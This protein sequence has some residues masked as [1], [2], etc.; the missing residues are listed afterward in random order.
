M[1]TRSKPYSLRIAQTSRIVKRAK[2]AF[3][4]PLSLALAIAASTA[5]A[6]APVF[7]WEQLQKQGRVSAGTVLPPESGSSGHPLRI[8]NSGPKS[9]SATVLTIDQPQL[10]GPRYMLRGQVRYDDVEGIGYL[11]MWSLF[12][13]GGQYFSRTLAEQGPMMK[14]SGTSGWRAFVLP[15]DAT[16]APRPMGWS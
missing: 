9:S 15:F 4:A 8:E 16:G 11:E 13:G 7:K 1:R 3:L 12:P 6:A 2:K 5:H 14:L 10:T